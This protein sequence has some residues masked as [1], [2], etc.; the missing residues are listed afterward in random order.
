MAS[1]GM[2]RDWLGP[3]PRPAHRPRKEWWGPWYLMAC[4]ADYAKSVNKALVVVDA[5]NEETPFLKDAVW[6]TRTL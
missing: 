4:F 3:R 1:F 2:T 5:I 6:N